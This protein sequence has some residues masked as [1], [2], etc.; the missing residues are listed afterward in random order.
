[1]KKIQKVTRLLFFP[2]LLA[3]TLT[4]VNAC[5]KDEDPTPVIPA[6]YVC[7]TC[8]DTPIAL[9]ANDVS[10]KG[11]YKGVVIGSTGTISINIQN[12][13]NDITATMVLDGQSIL[14]TSTVG[15]VDGQP[16]IAP[17]TGTFNGSAI[18]LTFSVGLGGE[19]PTMVT[20]DIPGHPNAIFDLYKETST[21]LIE[22]FEGSFVEANGK[23]G[24][25]NAIV[26][27]GLNKWGAITKSDQTGEID[28]YISGF[29]V[30][31]N[32]LMIEGESFI[33]ASINGDAL[34]A[35]L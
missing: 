17:F 7:T 9:A 33:V 14:L 34:M 8:A 24:T 10:N 15:V 19:N 35:I 27:R 32:Q 30:N 29:V 6:A 11:V 23:S 16:Y 26:S 25:F 28:N 2:A 3:G 1:M 22:A 21:S 18:S 5:S 20:S 13:S 4:L 12:G 31:N